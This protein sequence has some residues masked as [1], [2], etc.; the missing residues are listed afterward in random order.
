MH[1][2]RCG[3]VLAIM[4]AVCS[5]LPVL[6]QEPASPLSNKVLVVYL[7]SD[8]KAGAVLEQVSVQALGDRYFLV[9][10]G[11]DL[12]DP[13]RAGL[14][15]WIPVDDIGRIHQFNDVDELRARTRAQ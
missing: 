10:A 7:K 6:A 9:G 3:I 8:P 2:S 14:V 4:L 12:G 15:Q 11:V 13:T 1:C 5:A